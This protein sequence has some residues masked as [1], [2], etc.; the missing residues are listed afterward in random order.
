MLHESK[1]RL[2]RAF[3]LLATSVVGLCDDVGWSRALWIALL[4]TIIG[5]AGTVVRWRR[6]VIRH[7]FVVLRLMGRWR[8]TLAVVRWRWLVSPLI[9]GSL[10]RIFHIRRALINV[11]RLSWCVRSIRGRS[12]AGV[13]ILW[14][15]RARW[16]VER[17]PCT[18]LRMRWRMLQ[19]LRATAL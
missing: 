17:P 4:H 18:L 19:R 7:T 16:R 12:R 6:F 15:H 3:I 11:C 5:H 14:P 2:A 8:Q 9:E 1:G 10:S 13:R